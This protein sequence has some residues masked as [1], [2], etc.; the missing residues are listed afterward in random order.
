METSKQ[1][2]LLTYKMK[3]LVLQMYISSY[4][5]K[6]IG[7]ELALN[8]FSSFFSA[9][10]TIFRLSSNVCI[11]LSFFINNIYTISLSIYIQSHVKCLYKFYLI[12]SVEV[13]IY[14]L[15]SCICLNNIFIF[16]FITITRRPT[17]TG[18]FSPNCKYFD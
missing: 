10:D 16:K 15:I 1:C 18:Y 4:E 2:T 9:I 14:N 3:P 6:S 11:S 12:Y 8:V 7:E 5:T 13:F 17:S